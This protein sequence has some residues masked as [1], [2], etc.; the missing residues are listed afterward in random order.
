MQQLSLPWD[1]LFKAVEPMG[2]QEVA[3]LS[4]QPNVDK[5]IVRLTGEAKNFKALLAYL[6]F[7]EHSKTLNNV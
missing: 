6:T 4:I 2:E 1:A 5:R 3:L 7:L